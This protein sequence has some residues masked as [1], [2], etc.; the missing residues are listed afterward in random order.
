MFLWPWPLNP[1]PWKTNQFVASGVTR[2]GVS[3][4][5][6]CNRECR[7]YFFLKKTDDLFSLYLY[8]TRVS[9]CY[10]PPGGCHPAPFL[11]VRP[12]FS[13]ILYKFAHSF[14]PSDVTPWR[15]SP[16]RS[17]PPPQWCHCSWPNWC[18]CCVSF[19][20][21]AFSYSRSIEFVPEFYDH[22]W[23]TL[24]FDPVTSLM[25]TY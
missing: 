14:F 1:S 15:V 16:G 25:W 10:L 21:N 19:G 4:T 12:R 2:V 11:P 6:G 7:P 9:K 20:W 23:L 24:T 18:K 3:V 8:F 5:R 17:A 13:T 22:R